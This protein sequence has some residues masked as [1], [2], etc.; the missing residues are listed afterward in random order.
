[1]RLSSMAIGASLAGVLL[2]CSGAAQL[3][4][5][6]GMGPTPALPAPQRSLIP[7]VHIA[8]PIGWPA[9]AR[10]VA[11]DGLAVNRFADGLAHP[12]WV[13]VLANGDGGEG[14]RLL[15]LAIQ[16]LRS[17]RRCARKAAAPRSGRA[18]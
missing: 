3:P 5:T 11:A 16:L 15:R 17:A 14:G 13:Y 1:M 8:E 18:G 6:A 10:P 2:A 12:R 9:D 4:V 7:T